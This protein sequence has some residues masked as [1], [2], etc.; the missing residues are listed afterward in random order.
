LALT[1]TNSYFLEV[2][3][4]DGGLGSSRLSGKT[5]VNITIMDVNN[6]LP[7]FEISS[8]ES[9]TIAENVEKGHFVTRYFPQNK[10]YGVVFV[11][12]IPF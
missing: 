3:A 1:K 11:P 5:N 7:E 9:V 2:T 8:L 12:F 4:F 10:L 6:K